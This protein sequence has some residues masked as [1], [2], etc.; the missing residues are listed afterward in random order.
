MRIEQ[1]ECQVLISMLKPSKNAAVLFYDKTN[2]HTQRSGSFKTVI[3]EPVDSY[4]NKPFKNNAGLQQQH[5]PKGHAA[6]QTTTK[7]KRTLS[8]VE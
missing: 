4:R 7:Q 2:L 6:P 5:E 1:L 8:S 3:V